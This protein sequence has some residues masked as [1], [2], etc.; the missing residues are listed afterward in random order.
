MIVS[1]RDTDVLVLL[2]SYFYRMQYNELWVRAGTSKNRKYI[3]VLVI[4]NHI[5]PY[6]I[7]ALI[8]FHAKTSCGTSYI[9]GHTKLTAWKILIEHSHLLEAFVDDDTEN[10]FLNAEQFI[11][12]LY[13]VNN[14]N[15]INEVRHMLFF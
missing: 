3:P 13:G 11:C 6:I 8:P 1:C 2:I 14:T 10:N 5:P 12:R 15:N 7:P 4:V 9:S